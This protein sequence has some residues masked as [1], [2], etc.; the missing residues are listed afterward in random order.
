MA[1]KPPPPRIATQE[2]L[3]AAEFSSDYFHDFLLARGEAC[4][5]SDVFELVPGRPTR[6]PLF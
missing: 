3:M 5:I 2:F 6:L 1:A 4:R